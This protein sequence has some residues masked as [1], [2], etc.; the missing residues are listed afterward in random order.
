MKCDNSHN[1]LSEITYFK[2]YRDDYPCMILIF[3]NYKLF[4]L[5]YGK[6]SKS[7]IRVRYGGWD[8]QRKLPYCIAILDDNFYID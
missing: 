7:Y 6:L 2:P 8:I 1:I 3:E 4:N 5:I